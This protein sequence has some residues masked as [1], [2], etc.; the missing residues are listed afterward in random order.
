MRQFSPIHTGLVVLLCLA[1]FSAG[2]SNDSGSE[3]QEASSHDTSKEKADANTTEVSEED[4]LN[5]EDPTGKYGTGLTLAART[6]L[7]E[8]LADPETY[9]GELVQVDGVVSDV[10]PMRGCW[11]ELKEPQSAE[12]IRVKVTDG[13]IVFPLSARDQP[14]VIEGI[15]ER[16]DLDEEANR[17]W[18]EHL[19]EE[20][21]ETFDRESV[22]GP[23]VIWRIRGEGAEIGS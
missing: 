12:T 2:C 8:I 23:A 13:D 14:A 3:S 15:I 7:T 4:L 11:I 17:D 6:D 16:I 18:L 21:G 1:L 19:A 10:C 22:Q 9:E 5:K 20:R